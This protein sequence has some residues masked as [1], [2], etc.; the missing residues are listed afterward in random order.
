M[1]KQS[2]SG[3]R[4]NLIRFIVVLFVTATSVARATTV[5][6]NPSNT[7]GDW[8]TNTNWTGDTLPVVGDVVTLTNSGANYAITYNAQMAAASIG[9]LSLTN[10]TGFTTTLDVNADGLVVSTSS[11]S[12]S[13]IFSVGARSTLN[14]NTGGALTV[15]GTQGQVDVNGGVVKVEGGTLTFNNTS[16]STI[17]NGGSVVV[18]SG[19]LMD[20]SNS[21]RLGASNGGTLTINGGAVTSNRIQIANPTSALNLTGGTLT[22]LGASGLGLVV[23]SNAFT[24]SATITGGTYTNNSAAQ[25]GAS[26]SA[27]NGGKMTQT[28]GTWNQT[29]GNLAIGAVTGANGTFNF[30]G[31]AFN[32]GSNTV[33]VGGSGFTSGT[34]VLTI[35]GGTF[36]AGKLDVEYGTAAITGGTTTVSNLTVG[37]SGATLNFTGGSVN[38]SGTTSYSAATALQVGGSATAATLNLI[39]G[40][41]TFSSGLAIAQNGVLRGGGTVESAVSGVTSSGTINPGTTDAAG[42]LTLDGSLSLQST[43]DLAFKLGGTT[44]GTGYDYL[45]LSGAGS[46]LTLGGNLSV[47]FISGFNNTIT[48]LD[49]FT[50]LLA[51][52]GMTGLFANVVNGGTLTTS[53]GLGTFLVTYQGNTITLSNFAAVPEPNVLSLM[54]LS[55]IAVGGVVRYKRSVIVP[56]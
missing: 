15:A 55:L 7:S 3:C 43:S 18:N 50:V 8:N 52:G 31:G 45:H 19:T 38:V 47:S 9:R 54:L 33:Q 40:T 30:Q 28:S 34:N 42:T 49:T 10:S 29:G 12:A 41:H 35:S 23:G 13:I 14:V 4:L 26:G 39:S 56:V 20:K 32:G 36:S 27:G 11:T 21:L 6:W 25:I 17:Q 16:I 48:D 1:K 37:S 5:V 46:L 22:T 53:D 24:T 51:D 44:Q 2:R